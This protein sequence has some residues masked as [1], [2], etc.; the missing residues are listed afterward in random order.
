MFGPD[1]A[2]QTSGAELQTPH[3]FLK[4]EMVPA[5]MAQMADTI[6]AADCYVIVTAEYN[7]RS[8]GG[9]GRLF[10]PR[11]GNRRTGRAAIG[12]FCST[13]FTKRRTYVS[14]AHLCTPPPRPSVK[15]TP[16]SKPQR[17]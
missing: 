4:K 11:H 14:L 13:V 2:L 5:A 3:F 9:G 8:G 10:D 6:R 1:G 17:A 12:R 16:L 15:A 7:H